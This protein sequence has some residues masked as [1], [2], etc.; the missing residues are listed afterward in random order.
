MKN[1]TR[2]L[3]MTFVALLASAFAGNLN[4]EPLNYDKVVA[5]C[6]SEVNDR[7]ELRDAT[8]IRHKV[9]LQRQ[10]G[11]GRVLSIDTSVFTTDS[12]RSYAAYCVSSN[13]G[14]VL[15]FRIAE[16]KS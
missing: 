2:K 13:F 6:V 9:T 15:K 11:I 1:C 8:R 16:N 7:V 14:S 5:G 3:T 4:A 10:T 12:E